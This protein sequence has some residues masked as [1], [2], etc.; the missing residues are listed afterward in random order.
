MRIR[1]FYDTAGSA[2]ELPSNGDGY[3]AYRDGLYVNEQG[4]RG[5]FPRAT[6][7]P[8]TVNG[9]TNAPMVD[10]ET[11]D[12][13][14]KD[15]ARLA[16]DYHRATGQPRIIY[17]SLSDHDE[18][19]AECLAVGLKPGRDVLFFAARYGLDGT[20][21]PGFVGVQ[22]LS[23]DGPA[24]AQPRG[25]YDVS[26]VVGY[27]PGIDPKPRLAFLRTSSRRN[28]RALNKAI[29]KRRGTVTAPRDRGILKALAATIRR[30]LGHR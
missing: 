1:T 4:V 11:G 19:R 5:R 25:H 10:R 29:S 8:I 13:S 17:F 9:S 16:F 6:V 22:Y 3:L 24:N 28:A 2:S 12:V 30:V 21:P 18:V 15:A 26:H 23:P 20:I 27:V 14:A 7:I